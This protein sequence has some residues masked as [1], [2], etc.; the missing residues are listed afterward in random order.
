MSQRKPKT[1]GE[2]FPITPPQPV[3]A[4]SPPED[5]S[6]F[7]RWLGLPGLL[8]A[9]FVAIAPPWMF[10]SVYGTPRWLIGVALLVGLVSWW[11]ELSLAR[12][13][14]QQLPFMM[15]FVIAGGLL[16][17][18]QVVPLPTW[19]NDFLLG[20][21]KS[22]YEGTL[23]PLTRGLDSRGP[24]AYLSLDTDATWNMLQLM[25]LGFLAMLVG[26]RFVRRSF[27]S[28]VFLTAVTANGVVLAFFGIVQ[29]LTFNGKIY[30]QFELP[31]GGTPFGPFIN[32]N[33]AAG[34]LLMCLAA[35]VGL[36][37]LTW[38]KKESRIGS[39]RPNDDSA[40]DQLRLQALYLIGELNAR[41]IAVLTAA[42]FISAGIVSS[43][44]RGGVTGLMFGAIATLILFCVVRRPQAS[45]LLMI[46]VLG[47]VVLLTVWI[48]YYEQLMNRFDDVGEISQTTRV[49]SWSDSLQSLGEMG[50]LGSGLG[51]Y[52]VIQRIYGQTNERYAFEYAENQFV[53]TLVDAGIPGLILL[54]SAIALL[55]YLAWF[56]LR[57]GSNSLTIAVATMG[58]FLIT[59]QCVAATFDFG[60]YIPANT[61]LL[62]ILVGVVSQYSQGLAGRLKNKHFI[63]VS[64]GRW[65]ASIVVISSFV[66]CLLT[67]FSLSRRADMEANIRAIPRTF[68]SESP[69]LVET[70]K[71]IDELNRSLPNSRHTLQLNTL[72]E[73]WLHRSRLLLLQS[74]LASFPMTELSES[75][76]EE[77]RKELW[78]LTNL[79]AIEMQVREVRTGGSRRLADFRRQPYV[80][81]S[82]IPALACFFESL[83]EKPVQPE[84]QMLVGQIAS[85]VGEKE[86]GKSVIQQTVANS[87]KN[88]SFLFSA[89]RSFLYLDEYEEAMEFLRS[90][91]VL[92]PGRFKTVID[93][94][95]GRAGWIERPISNQ[96]IADKILP[97]DAT[98]L[99][100][101]AT[102]NLKDEEELRIQVLERANSTLKDIKFSDAAEQLLKARI[103]L[104]MGDMERGTQQLEYAIT[105]NSR[106]EMAIYDLAVLLLADG[107]VEKSLVF[108]RKLSEINNSSPKYKKLLKD[109]QFEFD[110]KHVFEKQE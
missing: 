24:T 19:A 72:G 3:D 9:L 102:Q 54:V 97:D 53:Q 60:W 79:A 42:V 94:V 56:A 99:F 104:A 6:R 58:I 101:F 95:Q 110:K 28:I 64:A 81:G 35:S 83:K 52:P 77:K 65:L 86:I 40:L 37:V 21:Q 57:H 26:F 46:P 17:L 29:K 98:L 73:L 45:V 1:L 59:S 23:G 78:N 48:G 36:I 96:T 49:Q 50:L 88:A 51:S 87:P 18:L 66:I 100:K 8:V 2:S 74:Q 38:V 75:K 107:E 61:V 93:L 5:E 30:W 13:R 47:T 71:W 31:N 90:S 89:G 69:N 68:S 92:E 108:A 15:L 106:N 91:L 33:N 11:L 63:A 12:K 44:S 4:S 41:K 34:Y 103:L 82:L 10:G 80:D 76:Q 85:V 70:E 32:R 84:I 39:R 67:V 105:M 109:A 25:L 16:G 20:A 55:T 22:I 14:Q 7:Q 62:G 43:L 27:E